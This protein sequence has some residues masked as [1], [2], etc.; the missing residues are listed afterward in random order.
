MTV[1][2][3]RDTIT[4]KLKQVTKD[5]DN[6]PELAYD[7]FVKTT[8]KRTGNARRNTSLRKETITAEYAYAQRLDQGYSKQ[9]PKGMIEPV[10]QFI[11]QQLSKTIRK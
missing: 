4:A 10:T 6:L 8:P 5:L 3:T 9:A 1:K 2:I 11:E 7:E